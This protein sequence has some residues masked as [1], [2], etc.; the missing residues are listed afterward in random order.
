M[1]QL[2]KIAIRGIKRNI[3]RTI[4]TTITICVGVF[5][6]LLIQGFLNG[7]HRGLI[8]NITNSRTGH[9]QIF[10]KGYGESA[11]SLPL[12]LSINENN[13]IYKNLENN[14]DIKY[15]TNRLSFAGM[16][17]TGEIS[18]MFV[19][20]GVD[21]EN[22]IKVC[23]KILENIERGRF[24]KKDSISYS[25]E[26]VVASPLA[27]S[28][29]VDVGDMI[30]LV[31]NTKHG[32][33]NAIDIEI[34]G[35]LTDRLPLGN[36][37]LIL[38]PIENARLVLQMQGESSEI[39]ITTKDVKLADNITKVLQE[40]SE[41]SDAQ[42]EV[43]PWDISAKIFKDIIIIQNAVF[44]VIKIVLLMIVISSIVNTM[45]MSIY[46]RVKEIGTMM[47]IGMIRQKVMML[48]ILET[49][50]LGILGGIVGIVLSGILLT[51]F[52]INGFTYTA[53][54]TNFPLTIYPYI[55]AFDVIFAY[56]FSIFASLISA[57]YPAYKG[58]SLLPTEALRTN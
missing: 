16:A 39:A 45:L 9:I 35:I 26:A 52:N 38:I 21:P 41:N 24:I 57:A 40:A 13:S 29:G 42:I 43:M 51:Y 19:A 47:A 30:T 49:I 20:I 37:K 48:F 17:N 33:M 1:K 7:L 56:L 53:P 36:K 54:G 2:I 6:I 28:L 3:R 25:S 58:A 12:N 50:I 46:E 34:V 32:A 23:P 4:I 14:K 5:V 44:W 27:K 15:Y 55:S 8:D 22:E 10:K 31:V 11:N 18:S